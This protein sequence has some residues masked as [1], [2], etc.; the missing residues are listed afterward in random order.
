MPALAGLW[1]I[2]RGD[3]ELSVTVGHISAVLVGAPAWEVIVERISHMTTPGGFAFT[4]GAALESRYR[5]MWLL[6]IAVSSVRTGFVVGTGTGV[7]VF[8]RGLTPSAILSS[9]ETPILFAT[10]CAM[11]RQTARRLTLATSFALTVAGDLVAGEVAVAYA[12]SYAVTTAATE[13]ASAGRTPYVAGV[14]VRR[15]EKLSAHARSNDCFAGMYPALM[16][17]N[18][19]G[20]RVGVNGLILSL[21][22]GKEYGGK[23]RGEIP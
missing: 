16:D 22:Q 1:A 11:G 17:A 23:R 2:W 20:R 14:A 9:V 5:R 8:V 19:T 3:F 6:L 21:W 13:A 4:L 7:G 10:D 18:V 15:A 12:V